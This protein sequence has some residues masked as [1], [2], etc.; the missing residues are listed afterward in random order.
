MSVEISGVKVNGVV[1]DDGKYY[2]D[3]NANGQY[4]EGD[5]AIGLT[6][7][8]LAE[9]VKLSGESGT[10]DLETLLKSISEAADGDGVVDL[11]KTLAEIDKLIGALKDNSNN[12]AY[13]EQ[14]QTEA[15]EILEMLDGANLS[16]NQQQTL[17]NIKT[18]LE[19]K[20]V[21]T[22]V[23]S[24]ADSGEDIG[25]AFGGGKSAKG[26]K[27]A[28]G[29]DSGGAKAGYWPNGGSTW[30]NGLGTFGGFNMDS[31][32]NSVYMDQAILEGMDSVN[33]NKM[34]Q[35]KM[36]MLFFYF[37]RMAA[38]GDLT[39]MYRFM[40]FVNWI[41]SKD[42]ALQNIH[43]ASKLI[44]YENQSKM[45]LQ[46]LLN[47]K[48]P[49]GKSMEEQMKFTQILESTRAQQSS[50]ATAQKLLAQMMEEMSQVVEMLTNAVKMMLEA[51]GRVGRTISGR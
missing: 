36:M 24:D 25:D 21:E 1:Q 47:T 33:K 17:D 40:Q 37:A 6:G 35:Q 13:V 42:K 48:P 18:S 9:L 45:A 41:V 32:L 44:E 16:E 5:V 30:N 10:V 4:D 50:M 3:A 46:E 26:G 11:L 34:E 20:G 7:A 12:D 22:D 39:A 19:E 14:L 49:D 38:S 2:I 15:Q 23:A 28:G 43:L 27:G 31:Y 8:E 51:A 29:G